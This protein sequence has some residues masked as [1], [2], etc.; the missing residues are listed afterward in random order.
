VAL[1]SSISR[2]S[3]TPRSTDVSCTKR[4]SGVVWMR[5]RR[6][7]CERMKPALRRSPSSVRATVASSLGSTVKRT[8]A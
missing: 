2:D 1:A 6:P 3:P 4:S 5:T 8:V 7:S